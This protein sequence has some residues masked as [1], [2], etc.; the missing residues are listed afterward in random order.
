MYWKDENGELCGIQVIKSK[1]HPYSVELHKAFLREK[2]ELESINI[3]FHLHY[4]I[5]PYC[6]EDFDAN[7]HWISSLNKKAIA[8]HQNFGGKF[9][10]Y[11]LCP[12]STFNSYLSRFH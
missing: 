2:L 3:R 8:M 11:A 6:K 5:F 7:P 9:T 10:F 12:P 4:V 1:Q